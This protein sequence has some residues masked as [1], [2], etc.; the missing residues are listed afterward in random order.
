MCEEGAELR[1]R[2]VGHDP[3]DALCPREE[4]FAAIDLARGD[5]P[6]GP[7]RPDEVP[8]P[9]ARFEDG[10]GGLHGTDERAGHGWR[11]HEVVVTDVAAGW[12]GSQTRRTPSE[13]ALKGSLA[14]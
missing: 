4:V 12:L 1:P 6:I 3:I 9:G 2:W 10:A 13:P 11:R 5:L 8:G 7:Q 14:T